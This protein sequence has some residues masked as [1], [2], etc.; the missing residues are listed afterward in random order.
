MATRLIDAPQA[1]FKF[2]QGLNQDAQY[3]ETMDDLVRFCLLFVGRNR[4]SDFIAFAEQ[5]ERGDFTT[6][7]LEKLWRHTDSDYFVINDGVRRLMRRAREIAV[8]EGGDG[9]LYTRRV[10]MTSEPK[11]KLEL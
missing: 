8:R 2:A 6:E 1:F 9:S 7:E 3:F 5:V 10:E 4:M 11:L